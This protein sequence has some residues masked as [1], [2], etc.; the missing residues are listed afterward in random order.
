[1]YFRIAINA[2]NVIK[3]DLEMD[4]VK[5]V[6]Y[7]VVTTI[8]VMYVMFV[9]PNNIIGNIARNVTPVMQNDLNIVL[10]NIANFVKNA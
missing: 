3:Q 2:T 9:Y 1:L 8:I 5:H 4:F 7:V 10:C 6:E